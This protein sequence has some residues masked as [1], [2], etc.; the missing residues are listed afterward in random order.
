VSPDWV[1]N[2]ISE[3]AREILHSVAK[4]WNTKY[5]DDNGR[6]ESGF[7][8]LVGHDDQ[9]E[10][11]YDDRQISCVRYLPEKVVKNSLGEDVVYPAKWRGMI[12]GVNDA[13]ESFVWLDQAWMDANV[14]KE[15]QGFVKSTRASGAEGYVRIPEGAAADHNEAHLSVA[16]QLE[17]P[18]LQY[19]RDVR[20]TNDR[21]CVLKGAASCLW[22][23]GHKRLANL[24][25]N[26]VISGFKMDK[27]FDYFQYVMD[28]KR[29]EKSERRAFQFV[30][31]KTN[32][33]KWDIL[34]D[35]QEYIMCLVGLLANDSKTDHAVAISGKWIFDSNLDYALPLSK[36]SLDL[37]CSND[38][39]K[40]QFVG[41]TRV[42]MLKSFN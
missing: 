34:K 24:L 42:F 39:N 29:L 9:S 38:K 1:E 23:L 2:N 22:F 28:P 10:F 18:K 3:E 25:C 8:S 4:D 40:N 11:K 31:L 37:C 20:L 30:K 13:R 19:T 16:V 41:V 14:S 27:G 6:V 36:D 35:S 15:M 7:L 5:T 21:T 32:P 26:D 17:T 12:K 33:K